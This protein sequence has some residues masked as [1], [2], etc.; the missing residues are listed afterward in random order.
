MLLA[1]ILLAAMMPL[2]A[3]R[4]AAD[5]AVCVCEMLVR[6]FLR[7]PESYRP[8]RPA[9]LTPGSVT[10][11]YSFRDARGAT[12]A[13]SRTC[14]FHLGEDGRFHLEPFR[15]AYLENRLT[16]AKAKLRGAPPGNAMRMLRSE[17][18]AIGR[19]MYVQDERMKRAEREAA[20]AGIYPIA[21]ADTALRE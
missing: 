5:P 7:T 20:A 16:A 18:L 3:A 6:Q 10:L 14:T 13:D 15:R 12:R 8:Q 19:E 9:I 2:Q 11:A 1:T 21:P 4:P 17:I